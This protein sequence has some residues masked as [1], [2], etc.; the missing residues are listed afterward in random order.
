MDQKPHLH[1]MLLDNWIYRQSFMFNF[2]YWMTPTKKNLET[3]K[4]SVKLEAFVL[5]MI[6]FC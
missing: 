6:L 3:S 2:K 5:K 4:C 1:F